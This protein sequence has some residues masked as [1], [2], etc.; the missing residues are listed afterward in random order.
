VVRAAPI[1]IEAALNGSRSLAEHSGTPIMPDEVAAAAAA[2]FAA[3]A[4]VAHIHARPG[5][6]PWSLDPEWYT[7]AIR[8]I[9]AKATGMLVSLTSIRPIGVQARSAIELL[10]ALAVGAG[11][12]PDLVSVNL[13]HISVW[14]P[15]HGGTTHFPND[16]ADVGMLFQ[17]CAELGVVPELGVMDLGFVNNAAM[18]RDA[19]LLPERP[20]FLLELDS[21]G[22]GFGSQVA[23]ATITNYDALAAALRSQFPAAAW[24]AHGNGRAMFDVIWRAIT[25]GAHV[26]VGFE[27]GVFMPDGRLATDNAQQV[28]WAVE[29]AAEF[30]RVPATPAEAREITGCQPD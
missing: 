3:G 5:G 24:A 18:V 20:W 13:G 6:V 14:D 26:R 17:G 25:T 27:D 11:T 15:L 8:A 28:R 10:K 22:Y 16:Y 4:T 19:G 23:P 1:L 12:K 9:R 7:D 29:V 21:P 2:C 30:K